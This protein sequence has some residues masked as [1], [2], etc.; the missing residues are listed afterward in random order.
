MDPPPVT[1]TGAPQ[2]QKRKYN[3]PPKGSAEAKERM[4]KV[5]AAQWAKNGLTSSYMTAN[6]AKQ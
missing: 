1:E 5:R 6:D 3:G 2:K 4:E